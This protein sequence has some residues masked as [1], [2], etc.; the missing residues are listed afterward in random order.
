MN[1]Y[2]LLSAIK[3]ELFDFNKIT[4]TLGWCAKTVGVGAITAAANTTSFLQEIKPNKVIFVGT[5]G[6]YNS[7]P[8]IGELL[9]VS[10]VISTSLDII[11][12]KS[13]KPDIEKKNWSSSL[14]INIPQINNRLIAAT[15]PGITNTYDGAKTLSSLASVENLELA[16]VFEACHLKK[17]ACSAIL[18]VSN[19]VGPNA[20]IEWKQYN[21]LVSKKLISVLITNKYL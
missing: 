3:D 1:S 16:G 7:K 15:T 17:I 6:S 19:K 14:N 8:E 18:A 11:N 13:Y 2:L 4:D 20:H 10:Q 12:G 9:I 5:C 21:K